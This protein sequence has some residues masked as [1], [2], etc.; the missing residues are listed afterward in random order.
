MMHLTDLTCRFLEDMLMRV[1]SL[2]MAAMQR[3]RCPSE[4]LLVQVV[5]QRETICRHPS[6]T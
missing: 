5:N 2:P 6:N 1:N 3:V 4:M